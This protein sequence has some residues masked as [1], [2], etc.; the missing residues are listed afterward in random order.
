MP[1]WEKVLPDDLW[2]S[3]VV[4]K[5]KTYDTTSAAG[6]NRRFYW[7][8]EV[9]KDIIKKEGGIYARNDGLREKRV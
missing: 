1:S 9:S 8:S 2:Y 7:P 5:L 6:E 4:S 3:D